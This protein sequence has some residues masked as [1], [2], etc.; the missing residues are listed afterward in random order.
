LEIVVKRKRGPRKGGQTYWN[1]MECARIYSANI[2]FMDATVEMPLAFRLRFGWE[3]VKGL[4]P[5]TGKKSVGR[6]TKTKA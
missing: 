1:R 5:I 6:N 4:N 2:G 3:I